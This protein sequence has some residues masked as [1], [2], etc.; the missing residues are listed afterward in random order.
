MINEFGSISSSNQRYCKGLY[1]REGFYKG[2]WD[3]KVN[4][5]RKIEGNSLGDDGFSLAELHELHWRGLM[6]GNK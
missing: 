1:K 6:L 4:S 3:K 5:K 2:E